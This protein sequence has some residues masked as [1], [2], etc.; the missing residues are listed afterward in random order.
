MGKGSILFSRSW[1]ETKTTNR[2]ILHPKS[3]EKDH[4]FGTSNKDR[5]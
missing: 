4:Y 2:C 5:M 1:W 3:Q